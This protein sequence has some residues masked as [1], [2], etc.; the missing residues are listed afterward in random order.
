MV[1]TKRVTNAEG[2]KRLKIALKQLGSA[3]GKVG[4]FESAKYPDGTPVAGVA[5]VQ[6]LGSPSRNIPPR[7]TMRPAAVETQKEFQAKSG[8][9]MKGILAG[10]ETMFS[11]MEKLCDRCAGTIRKNIKALTN[12]P[13]KLST[14][15]GRLP[16]SKQGKK[17]VSITVAKPLV[18]T[19][20]LLDSPTYLVEKK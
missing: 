16:L 10:T 18:R 8:S 7:P 13:L 4:Y 12:P 2:M 6:E 20:L 17:S 11:V 14:I 19:G 9:A 15:L 5:A 3:Q 1:K